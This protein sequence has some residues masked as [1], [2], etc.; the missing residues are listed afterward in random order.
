MRVWRAG[1]VEFDFTFVAEQSHDLVE[2]ARQAFEAYHIAHPG[3]SLLDDGV[4]V[5]FEK[6]E[7]S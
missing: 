5:V 2:G 4:E 7:E 3:S 6:A 1:H